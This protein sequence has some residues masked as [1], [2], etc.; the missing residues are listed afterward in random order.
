MRIST[1]IAVYLGNDTRQAH[2]Y[3][4]SII[5]SPQ[6]ADRSLSVPMTLSDLERRD[7]K[8]Q[9]ILADIHT[10]VQ[11]DYNDQILRVNTGES[12]TPLS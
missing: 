11:F 10:L 12:A 7:E 8:G 2:G 1:E 6:K 5:G 9:I 3:Y 4:G